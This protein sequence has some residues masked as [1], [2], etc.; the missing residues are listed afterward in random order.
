MSF[1]FALIQLFTFNFAPVQTVPELTDRPV[2]T[3][4]APSKS[5]LQQR[6]MPVC[7]GRACR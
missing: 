6:Q 4:A 1:M 5:D 2:R 3:E 7:L